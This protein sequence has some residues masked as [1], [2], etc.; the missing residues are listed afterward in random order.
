MSV[1][2]AVLW[3]CYQNSD[4]AKDT[5]SK[6]KHAALA[7]PGE[8]QLR[9]N[10]N[11]PLGWWVVLYDIIWP[12]SPDVI[13]EALGIAS[14]QSEDSW[15]EYE[16]APKIRRNSEASQLL[17]RHVVEASEHSLLT[18]Q[19]LLADRGLE[20]AIYACP[21]QS[22]IVRCG[23]EVNRRLDLLRKNTVLPY[24]PHAFYP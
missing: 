8:I 21:H 5:F 14:R 16:G 18:F 11:V 15:F 23:D 3:L 10:A 24:V 22:D 2:R 12:S 1:T 7:G 17:D 20:R 6:L 19:K 13:A 4:E 9:Y